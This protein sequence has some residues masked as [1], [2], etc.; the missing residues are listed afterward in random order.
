MFDGRRRIWSC[1]DSSGK[2]T[3]AVH[4]LHEH[5]FIIVGTLTMFACCKL[6]MSMLNTTARYG[7]ALYMTIQLYMVYTGF[8]YCF[9]MAAQR[10]RSSAA[11]TQQIFV[12]TLTG[13]TIT[14]DVR[15]SDTIADTRA[16]ISERTKIPPHSQRL[17]CSGKQLEDGHVLSDC[18]IQR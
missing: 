1:R 15:V 3:T 18:N 12:K 2:N 10:G 16:A 17:N 6:C 11:D 9:S 5:A 8:I 4:E 7:T 13:K 14:L